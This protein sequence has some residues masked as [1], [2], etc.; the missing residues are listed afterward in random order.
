MIISKTPLRI[1][2]GGGGTDLPSYYKTNGGGFLVAAAIN[3]HIY[4]SVHDNFVERI[5]L[6]YSKIENVDNVEHIEHPII[7]EALREIGPINGIE[8]S[9]QADIPAGTGLGSSGTF[10]V[11]LLKALYAHQNWYVSNLEIAETACRL[12]IETLGNPVGKQDQYIAAVGGLTA[13]EFGSSGEVIANSVRMDRLTRMHLEENLLLFYTGIQRSASDELSALDNGSNRLSISIKENLDDVKSAGYRSLQ[14]LESGNL[15]QF[16][17]MLTDQWKL[18]LQRSNTKVNMTVDGWINEGI[19]AGAIGGKLVGAGGGG[20]LLFY[21]ENKI[22][23]RN[24]MR[25]LGLREIGFSFDYVGS[26]LVQ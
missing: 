12:E 3:K 26:T 1:S 5:L 11:G 19:S 25:K 16:G 24:A 18:K 14:V 7:R 9:S 13:F 23:L 21:S 15:D 6:K 2:L 8:I 10:T 20:F 17:R 22:P 4:L